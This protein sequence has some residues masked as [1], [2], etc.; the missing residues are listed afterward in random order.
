[1]GND[2]YTL[3]GTVN[4]PEN[5]K[6]EFSDSILKLLYMGGIRKTEEMELGGKK[7]TV[8]GRPLPDER[9]I[10]RFDYSII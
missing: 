4:I 9:G 5:R 2:L 7:I 8:V 3:A 1:M 6:A 10:V